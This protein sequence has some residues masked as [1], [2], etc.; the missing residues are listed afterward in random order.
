[1][2]KASPLFGW[3]ASAGNIP[4]ERGSEEGAGGSPGADPSSE[5]KMVPESTFVNKK[6]V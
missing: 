4:P 1:M 5:P 6:M 3:E 2:G